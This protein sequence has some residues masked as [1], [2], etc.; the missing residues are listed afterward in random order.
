MSAQRLPGH[1][2]IDPHPRT[3][4][5]TSSSGS[6]LPSRGASVSPQRSSRRRVHLVRIWGHAQGAHSI[7]TPARHDCAYRQLPERADLWE[8][9]A[10]PPPFCA[11]LG[12]AVANA[13]RSMICVWVVL[14]GRGACGDVCLTAR[15]CALR[16]N[17]EN[18]HLTS[19][20]QSAD[21]LC[22]GA[23][24]LV[25]SS[26]RCAT[27]VHA[28]LLD[29][30]YIRREMVCSVEEAQKERKGKERKGIVIILCYA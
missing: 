21:A 18:L 9:C 11:R 23:G 2:D 24:L 8:R 5:D 10:A 19:G 29:A 17:T 1:A 30:V 20:F 4:R 12:H 7:L 3:H 6:P 14:G 28:V 16:K 22:L 25:A 15:P 27:D 26:N 13:R